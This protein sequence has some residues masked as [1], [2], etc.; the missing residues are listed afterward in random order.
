MNRQRYIAVLLESVQSGVISLDETGKISMVNPAAAQL[1]QINANDLLGKPYWATIPEL[2]RSEFRE[3]L[4]SVFGTAKPVR[5]EFRIRTANNEWVTVL[6]PSA[7][8][9]TENKRKQLGVVAVFD[10]VT[11]I[12]KMERMLAWREVAKR[13]A[14]EIKNPLTPIQL[15]VQR[16]QRRYLDRINGRR[17]IQGDEHHFKRRWIHCARW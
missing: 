15:S 7:C 12:Q 11:D 16:L 14:H 6:A 9:E 10:D 1:L 4:L 5:R 17:D 8:C 13:I 2:H 3:L